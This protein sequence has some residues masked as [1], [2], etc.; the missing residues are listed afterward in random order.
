MADELSLSR[1]PEGAAQPAAAASGTEPEYVKSRLTP[2]QLLERRRTAQTVYVFDLRDAE[3]FNAG[4]IPGAY[5]LP[6]EHVEAN[7]HRLPFSGELLFYDGGEGLTR[8]T[9]ALLFDNGFADYWYMEDG[10]EALKAA[11]VADPH[12]VNYQVLAPAE[13]A[14]KVEE[15]LDSKVRE[16]LARDGGGMEVIG[17][18][19]NRVVVSYQGAC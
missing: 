18:E 11:M 15:V 19:E 8:Q 4:H 9:A 6:F 10:Y 17:I 14:A 7:L 5:N 1:A 3:A 16:F 12:E 2:T 13:K